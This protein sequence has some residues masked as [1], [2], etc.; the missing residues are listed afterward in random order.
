V[1]FALLA[2]WITPASAA[3]PPDAV[4]LVATPELADPIYGATVLVARPIGDGQF[5]GFIINKPTRVTLA[6]A[7]PKHMP[8]QKVAAPIF[9]GGP[10]EANM[11]FALVQS[12]QSPGQGSIQL[13]PD[14]FIV[15][16]GATVD[17]V[18]E[19]DPDHARFLVGVVIWR[20]GELE[21]E[22]KRGA[23]YV[24]QPETGLLMR[25]ET[26]NL[27]EELVERLEGRRKSI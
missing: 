13:T 15:L 27:W 24:E 6:Q 12:E 21:A 2:A 5:L 14:L 16:A 8:S 17:E 1:A 9:L 26:G 18:I 20:P 23:W 22:I 11:L 7:F 25:K 4:M 3:D 10:E 19:H